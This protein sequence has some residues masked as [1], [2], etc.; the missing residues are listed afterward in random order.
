[1]AKLRELP[2]F[3]T[4]RFN[5]QPAIESALIEHERGMFRMSG[6]LVDVMMRDTRV[7]GAMRT[8]IQGLLGLP[9]DMDPMGDKRRADAVAKEAKEQW[10]EMFPEDQLYSWIKYGLTVGIGVAQNIVDTTSVAGR[11]IPHMK[12]W[13]PQNV[14]WD[15]TERIYRIQTES[16]PVDLLPD[17][18]EWMLYLPYGYE[19]GW[20]EGLVR[21][22]ADP[23][24]M[25][26]WARRDW[27]RYSE[28]HGQPI[29]IA[30][31]PPT[32]DNEEKE[33]WHRNV[34]NLG[35]ESTLRTEDGGDGNKYDLEFREPTGDSH[36]CFQEEID[37]A[38]NDITIA[39]LGN[40]LNGEIKQG[41]FA[42]SKTADGVRT[43]LRQFDANTV[44]NA[45]RSGSLKRWAQWN[46]GDA[47]LAPTPKWQTEEAPDEKN[48][49]DT[50]KSFGDGVASLKAAGVNPDVEAL[51]DEFGIPSLGPTTAEEDAAAKAKAAK[52][53]AKAFTQQPGVP[54][55][56]GKPALRA[57]PGNGTDQAPEHS[58]QGEP[59]DARTSKSATAVTSIAE[60]KHMKS[61]RQ[62]EAATES[63]AYID[64]LVASATDLGRQF[65]ASKRK[66]V[67]SAI[68]ESKDENDLRARLLQLA[69]EWEPGRLADAIADARMV[70]EA[71]GAFAVLKEG[72][73]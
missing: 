12:V 5:S 37:L 9:L 38:S 54:V 44:A 71:A 57:L 61:T 63:Q 69:A 60:A 30:M 7:A 35:S 31:C 52:E 16:G 46:F 4:G 36:E 58:G 66:A 47:E 68:A 50:L 20:M 70:G 49:A 32:A 40:N 39:I 33:R 43:D 42:A 21:P 25:R 3:S 56:P 51:C 72:G 22:L 29:K 15:W 10:P 59:T 24:L 53:A 14:W 64:E 27:A 17:D 19:R 6:N 34:S 13:H 26:M 2:N 23:W 65:T 62:V 1:M 18:P 11:W 48:A 8:R 73:A 67:L 41:S 55:P 45:L 28:V